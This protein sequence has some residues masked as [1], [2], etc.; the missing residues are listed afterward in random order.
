[1]VSAEP[2]IAAEPPEVRAIARSTLTVVLIV[3]SIVSLTLAPVTIWARNLILDTNGY[4]STMAPLAASPQM[5]GAVVKAVEKQVDEHLDVRAYIARVLP[6]ASVQRFGPTLKKA[7]IDLVGAVTTRFV[8]SPQFQQLWNRINH[9]AHQQVD[10]LLVGGSTLHGVVALQS[11]SVVL[12]LSRVVAIV[13]QRL[14]SA[15]VGIAARVPTFGA[16]LVI[17]H[18]PHLSQI[19]QGVRALNAIANLLPWLGLALAAGALVAAR[20][21]RQA[22]VALA[23]GLAGGMCLLTLG[24]L[25]G[26]QLFSAQLVA[27]GLAQGT[28]TVLFDTVV[29]NLRVALRV[30]LVCALVIAGLIWAARFIPEAQIPEFARERVMAPFRTPAARFVARHATPLRVAV[31]AVPVV[32]LALTDGPPLALVAVF[33]CVVAVA[34]GLIELCRRVPGAGVPRPVATP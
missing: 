1:M 2:G 31:I 21:R 19:Q 13:K 14:V 33:A 28:V 18:I 16:T 29:R 22:G 7:T 32:I 6:P 27:H 4:V 34:E 5:Q 11:D 24:L 9:V 20:R 25:V 3:L 10:N 12:D 23:L 8:T 26:E 17:A 15:G 30:I